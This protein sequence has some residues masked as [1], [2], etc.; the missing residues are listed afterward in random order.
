MK[1][2]NKLQSSERRNYARQR[3][4]TDSAEEPSSVGRRTRRRKLCDQQELWPLIRDQQNQLTMQNNQDSSSQI[5]TRH[6]T[7]TSP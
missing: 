6:K 5:V 7:S 2:F 4:N 1:N 3:A